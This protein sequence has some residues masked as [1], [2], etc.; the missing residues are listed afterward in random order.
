[1]TGASERHSRDSAERQP[2]KIEHRV[3]PPDHGLTIDLAPI[4][5]IDPVPHAAVANALRI[6]ELRARLLE[7]GAHNYESLAR[8]RNCTID[9]ARQSVSRA[10][11]KHQL[12]TVQH[13]ERTFVPQFLLDAVLDPIPGFAPIIARLAEVGER[14]WAAWT[15]LV[16]PSSWLD[17]EIPAEMVSRGNPDPVYEAV[18]RR[19]SNAT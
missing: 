9:A 18:T 8:G 5:S 4:R 17:G 13:E 12:I 6:R 1:M 3:E 16:T 10:R 11:A 2:S 19:T 15:W 14:E 7:S